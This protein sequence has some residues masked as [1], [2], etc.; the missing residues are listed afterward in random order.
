MALYS[1]PSIVQHAVVLFL[2]ASA[3]YIRKDCTEESYSI[4]FMS[5]IFHSVI[6]S[7][8]SGKSKQGFHESNFPAFN[9]ASGLQEECNQNL[10]HASACSAI[11]CLLCYMTAELRSEITP[12]L[13]RL[14][15]AVLDYATSPGK[16]LERK[17]RNSGMLIYSITSIFVRLLGSAENS[18]LL[19]NSALLNSFIKFAMTNP[20]KVLPKDILGENKTYW[21]CALN[22]C[23]QCVAV[24][25]I[26]PYPDVNNFTSWKE[27]ISGAESVPTEN[28]L[29]GRFQKLSIEMARKRPPSQA[30]SFSSC[31]RVFI[32]DSSDPCRSITSKQILERLET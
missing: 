26:E 30:A 14:F 2:S 9:N 11:E 7:P 12:T 18:V 10:V 8:Q 19:L 21:D 24:L 13:E 4:H 15:T 32:E 1:G 23:L 22:Q 6:E 29:S 25:T 5:S 3:R 31:L 28:K 27:I 17:M 20:P 16:K